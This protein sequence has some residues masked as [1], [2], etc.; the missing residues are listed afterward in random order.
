MQLKNC[1]LCLSLG[2]YDLSILSANRLLSLLN[3]SRGEVRTLSCA[4]QTGS[5]SWVSSAVNAVCSLT[6]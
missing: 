1:K 5:V 6:T 2:V 4:Q 3:L